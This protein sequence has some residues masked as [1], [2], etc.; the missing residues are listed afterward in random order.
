M[1]LYEA[2]HCRPP[3]EAA[4]SGLLKV[5][6]LPGSPSLFIAQDP[7]HGKKYVVIFSKVMRKEN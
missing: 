1:L 4:P 5:F 3:W 6:I 7:L 2:A